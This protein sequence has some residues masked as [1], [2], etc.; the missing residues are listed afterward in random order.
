MNFLKQ[1]TFNFFWKLYIFIE[2]IKTFKSFPKSIKLTKNKN[3]PLINGYLS[4]FKIKGMF[5]FEDILTNI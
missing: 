4:A 1:Q 3:Q 2:Y 5:D